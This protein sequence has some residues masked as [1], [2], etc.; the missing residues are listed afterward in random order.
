MYGIH[1]GFAYLPLFHTVMKSAIGSSLPV[2]VCHCILVDSACVLIGINPL[3]EVE[4][5]SV[6][7]TNNDSLIMWVNPS[8]TS[9]PANQHETT[10]KHLM[11]L[12]RVF[13]STKTTQTILQ[14]F[15]LKQVQIWM[16]LSKVFA[17][18]YFRW[19]HPCGHRLIFQSPACGCINF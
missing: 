15:Y 2:T 16:R 1:S 13:I 6:K 17:D 7:V 19:R 10:L 4:C 12:M 9:L 18:L 14:V 3:S 8:D 5:N 11:H